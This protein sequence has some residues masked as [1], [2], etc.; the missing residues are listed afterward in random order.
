MTDQDYEEILDALY[1]ELSAWGNCETPLHQLL[2]G[3]YRALKQLVDE[4]R[5]KALL[6]NAER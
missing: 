2:C 5:G 4:R 1:I 3:A 6:D